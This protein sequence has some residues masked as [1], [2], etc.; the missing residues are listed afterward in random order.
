MRSRV[1]HWGIGG[2][3]AIMAVFYAVQALGMWSATAPLSFMADRWYFIAPLA[4]GFAVQAAL[5]RAMH[6]KAMRAGVTAAASGGVS[7]GAMAACCLHNLVPLVPVLGTSGVAAFFSA[8]QTPVFLAS[9][10]FVAIGVAV[11]WRR[12]ARFHACCADVKPAG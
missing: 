3:V 7:A 5:F 9:I 1:V 8:Y 10:A 2:L 11:M 4:A 6:E 12:Y